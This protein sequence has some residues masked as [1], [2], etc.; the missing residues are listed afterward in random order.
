MELGLEE[1]WH[2]SDFKSLFTVLGL[3][4]L[5]WPHSNEGNLSYKYL[6]KSVLG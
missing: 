5:F 2:F 3:S 4:S 1:T 6:P